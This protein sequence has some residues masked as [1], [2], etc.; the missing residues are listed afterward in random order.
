MVLRNLKGT[1]QYILHSY[2]STKV[3][4]PYAYKVEECS[5]Q[6]IDSCFFFF[7]FRSG[8]SF[9]FG[10]SYRGNEKKFETLHIKFMNN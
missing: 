3:G 6:Y 9:S 1:S 8:I 2:I 4:I 10:N 7:F 5:G